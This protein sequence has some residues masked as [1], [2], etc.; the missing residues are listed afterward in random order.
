MKITK[1][2]SISYDSPEEKERAI[3]QFHLFGSTEGTEIWNVKLYQTIKNKYYRV[4]GVF[5]KRN[6][7]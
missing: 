7:K 6:R 2:V 3:E 5:R 1:L 4:M